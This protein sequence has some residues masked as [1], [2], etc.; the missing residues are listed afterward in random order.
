MAEEFT[1][2]EIV[3]MMIDFKSDVKGLQTEMLETRSMLKNYNGL[4]QK[5]MDMEVEFAKFKQEQITKHSCKKE[6][7]GDWKWILG[8]II[9]VGSLVLNILT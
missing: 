8:W 6:I 9:A 4:R 7:K 3:E 2:K 5:L 1:N